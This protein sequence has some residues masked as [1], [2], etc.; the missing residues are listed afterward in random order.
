[1]SDANGYARIIGA[2]ADNMEIW[3]KINNGVV[4]KAAYE[5]NGCWSS[6]AA[7]CAT[8]ILAEGKAIEAARRIKPGEVIDAIGGLPEESVHC[9][10]LAVGTLNAAL[11]DFAVNRSKP[12]SEPKP[13][14][15]QG[16][17]T[18]FSA[19]RKRAMIF[20]LTTF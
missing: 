15:C 8:T 2:C 14:S 6:Q 12:E 19:K 17:C 10:Q 18:I 16:L 7:G 5:T 13:A 11:D 20:L 3:L 9:A 1:M 4:L